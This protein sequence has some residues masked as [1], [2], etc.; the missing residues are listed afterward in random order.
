[1]TPEPQDG[2]PRPRIF[3]LEK[4]QAI[5]NRVGLPSEGVDV[6]KKRL[7]K[8]KDFLLGVNCAKQ[9][10][11]S[12]FAKVASE[13]AD[14]A[15][16]VVI[17]ASCPNVQGGVVA[18]LNELRAAIRQTKAVCNK[19][20]MVKL[21]PDLQDT[22]AVAAL[23][24]EEHIDGVIVANTSKNHNFSETGGLSGKP[25]TMNTRRL[26]SDIYRHT[27]GKLLI[28]GVGG[29]SSAHDAYALIRAGATLVQLYTGLVYLGPSSTLQ[30]HSDLAALVRADGFERLQDAVGIDCK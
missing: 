26:V 17:N 10:S 4:E 29:I 27:S 22:K 5:I 20:V 13:V 1:M 9:N 30:L 12:D 14:E 3:R 25:L 16:F 24:L 21:S 19:I 2:N 6:V 23:L 11:V 7:L 15:D 18:D 8:Q 28:V